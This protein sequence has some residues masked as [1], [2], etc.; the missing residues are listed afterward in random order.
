MIRFAP[1]LAA[2]VLG[3][4]ALAPLHASA[5]VSVNINIGEAP[6]PVRYEPAPPPRSGYVWAPGFWDWK[7][8][9]HV[10]IAGHWER[11]RGGY[12]YAPAEWRHEGGEWRLYRGG[13]HEDE[14]HH[15]RHHDRDRDHDDDR[16]YHCPPGQAKKG[17]C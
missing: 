17:R 2:G 13:W 7:G 9:R 10:W 3:I 11:A 5:Q 6:P 15:K 14:H 12:V 4:A 8:N 1:L 16:G